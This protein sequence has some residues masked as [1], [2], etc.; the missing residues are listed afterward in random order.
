MLQYKYET[1]TETEKQFIAVY[2]GKDSW[3]IE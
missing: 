2:D 1:E 3:M